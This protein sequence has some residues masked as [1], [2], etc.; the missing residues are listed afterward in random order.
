[1]RCPHGRMEADRTFRN[2]TFGT[3]QPGEQHRRAD[4]RGEAFSGPTYAPKA[5]Y[6]GPARSVE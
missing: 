3:V 6:E 5:E 1:M 4:K 2:R